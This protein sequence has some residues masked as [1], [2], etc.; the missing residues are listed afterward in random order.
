MKLKDKIA[1]VTGA[2]SGMGKAIATEF[3]KEGAKVY[4]VARRVEKLDEL[5]KQTESYEGEIIPVG[6][7]LMDLEAAAKVIEEVADKEGKLDILVNNAGIMDNFAGVGNF[8]DEALKNIFQ[9]N[10]FTPFYTSREAIKIFEKQGFG[11]I[12]NIASVGGLNG[13]RGGS[14][15]TASKHAVIGLTKNT[16]YIYTKKNIRCNAICPGGVET[17]I[18]KGAYMQNIDKESREVI[19]PATMATNPRSGKPEEIAKVAVF[20][21]SD[22]SGFINGQAIAVDAGWTAY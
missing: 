22:D 10:T 5:K 13:A 8:D 11:N 17:D 7:D 21:A 9:L 16:A 15:Y 19:L 6:R 2:S 20:L 4:A 14:I 12:I 3:A 18:A 1:I